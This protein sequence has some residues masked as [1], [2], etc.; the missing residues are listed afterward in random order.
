MACFLSRRPQKT[1]LWSILLKKR[2]KFQ[3]LA[4]KHWLTP[5]TQNPWTNATFRNGCFYTLKWL[6]LTKKHG[7]IPLEK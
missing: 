2:T 1:F 4:K 5:L 3:I 7:L 6:V